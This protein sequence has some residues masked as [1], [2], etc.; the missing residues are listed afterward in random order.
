[1]PQPVRISGAAGVLL[2][3]ALAAATA[4]PQVITTRAYMDYSGATAESN[5]FPLALLGVAGA[6][7]APGGTAAAAAPGG[8]ATYAFTLR[9]TGSDPDSYR[10]SATGG[11]TAEI[12]EDADNDGRLD[13][14]GARP[15]TSIADLAPDASRSF[16]VAVHVPADAARG[17]TQR[18]EILAVSEAD[19]FQSARTTLTTTVREPRV[20]LL[21][22]TSRRAGAPGSTAYHPITLENMGDTAERFLVQLTSE[23]AWPARVL[24]DENEDGSRQE[25]ETRPVEQIELG[26]GG[27]FHAFVAVLLPEGAR[28]SDLL[29]VTCRAA[30]SGEAT[31]ATVSTVA[32]RV[33]TVDPTADV[34]PISPLIYGLTDDG[35]GSAA[36]YRQLRTPLITRAMPLD[37]S[38]AASG[39][40]GNPAARGAGPGRRTF[41][42]GAG[43]RDAPAPIDAFVARNRALG[44]ATLL[45]SPPPGDEWLRHLLRRFGPAAQGGVRVYR[46]GEDPAGSPAAR[47]DADQPPASGYDEAYTRFVAAAQR[48]KGLDPSA[49]VVGPSP[50]AWSLG[51]FAGADR[52]ERP[53]QGDPP[54]LSW[55]LQRLQS[56]TSSAGRLLDLL[57][58]RYR[59][60]A[61]GLLEGRTDPATNDLRLRATR[62]LWD[63]S[64]V[65]ESPL[66][67]EVQLLPRLRAWAQQ[68]SPETKIALS[69]W[70]WGADRTVNGA[71]AIAE[72]LGILGREDAGLALYGGTPRVL[73]PAFQVFKLMRNYNGR[74]AGFGDRSCRAEGS[75]DSLS[76][77]AS[78][79]SASGAL[80]LLLINKDPAAAQEV[81]VELRHF[82]SAVKGTRIQLAG[83]DF[84]PRTSSLSVD[85][86]G[87]APVLPPYSVTL[88]VLPNDGGAP[89]PPGA[90][91]AAPAGAAIRLTWSQSEAATSYHLYRSERASGPFRRLNARPLPQPEMLDRRV[92][93]GK[94]YW[95]RATALSRTG[96]ESRPS[97]ILQVLR[98]RAS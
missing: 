34:H 63:P 53:S 47:P 5:A 57:D 4:S 98:P 52:G 66:Q 22:P 12:A 35:L 10:L 75:D 11:W 30:G 20:R 14:A 92:A 29:R 37:A 76:A 69:G 17:A 86:D 60:A 89:A 50:D 84:R 87:V 42:T 40:Q 61:P 38:A 85:P 83:S 28:G 67:E 95:Y 33:V 8:V 43:V 24:I 91:Q 26:A 48:V 62:S 2:G 96:R 23:Q 45:S 15:L 78:R 94:P 41:E 27:V 77:Y 74:G 9:N 70:G 16:L 79:D 54:F 90:P 56:E 71:L 49:L 36:I 64:Y 44:A 93:A 97:G 3:A 39:P 51:L 68:Y 13:P 6:Q 46:V 1:M 80:K 65:D 59:P 31:S 55:F 25:N 72:T 19:S 32:G 21:P 18:T 81:Q 73:S 88:L 58:V 82:Q 7:L